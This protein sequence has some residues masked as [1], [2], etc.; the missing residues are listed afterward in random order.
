MK[1]N[2]FLICSNLQKAKT[3]VVKK[4]IIRTIF[5]LGFCTGACH[6]NGS[7]GEDKYKSV[8]D[9]LSEVS[10]RDIFSYK[11]ILFLPSE[12][13]GGCISGAERFLMDEYLGGGGKGIFFVI[14]G[15]HSEKNA[16][17]R[18]GE[19][20]I[21]NADIYFDYSNT[22]NKPPFMQEFPKIIYLKNG[23]VIKEVNINEKTGEE[24]YKAL[25]KV[26]K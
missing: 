8:L 10:Q 23:A 15:V 24:E 2:W 14:S 1:T 16:R 11:G 3:C 19:K 26:I 7:T 4:I 12:G 9:S 21:G 17:L 25:G 5:L 18:F 22:F 6:N 13:C 20:A